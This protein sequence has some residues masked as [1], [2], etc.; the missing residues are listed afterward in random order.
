M[1]H[2][3]PPP[4]PRQ[5]FPSKLPLIKIGHLFFFEFLE[6]ES[7]ELDVPTILGRVVEVERNSG[8]TN[9]R[10]FPFILT[11]GYASHIIITCITIAYFLEETQ[12]SMTFSLQATEIRVKQVFF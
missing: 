9:G 2:L 8:T 4:S 5:F 1:N 6:R 7:K 3:P 10:Y 12:Y 11:S